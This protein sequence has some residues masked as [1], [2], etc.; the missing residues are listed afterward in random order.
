MW[1][2]A[3]WGENLDAA[4]LTNLCDRRWVTQQAVRIHKDRVNVVAELQVT[5]DHR[6]REVVIKY[7]GWR[8][9]ISSWLSPFMRSR[10]RKSWDASWWLL[11]HGIAVPRPVAVYTK[12]R[13]GFIQQNFLLT[14]KITGD[15]TARRFLRDET[16]FTE[17]SAFVRH[18]SEIVRRLHTG[19]FLH[20]DLTLGNFLLKDRDYNQIYLVDLNRLVRRWFVTPRQRMKDIARMNLCACRLKKTHPD[21]LWAV[22]LKYYEPEKMERNIHLLKKALHKRQRQQNFKRKVT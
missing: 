16:S 13:W 3:L 11:K 19:R 5:I 8:N 17:K 12:R 20:R 2:R 7:F 1:Y 15:M 9:R 10:A 21:C 18:L 4:T 6:P 14:E 22:F